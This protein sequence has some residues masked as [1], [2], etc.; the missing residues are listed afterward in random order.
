MA[1]LRY[2]RIVGANLAV[3]AA[4]FPSILT[5]VA[6]KR[7]AHFSQSIQQG[8]QNLTA[9]GEGVF[10]VWRVTAEVCPFEQSVFYHVAQP[11]PR[12]CDY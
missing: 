12:E 4:P 7:L 2:L 10:D 8:H 6:F 5:L 1:G 9:F 11:S 3:V